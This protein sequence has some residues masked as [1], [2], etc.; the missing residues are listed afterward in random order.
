VTWD[1]WEYRE[2][3]SARVALA[4]GWKHHPKNPQLWV[5]GEREIFTGYYTR[6]RGRDA[7]Q[8]P[9]WDPAD[10][11]HLALAAAGRMAD[12]R[13]AP[14][15]LTRLRDGLWRAAFTLGGRYGDASATDQIPSR[16]ICAAILRLV[17]I[18]DPERLFKP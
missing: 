7:I 13:R 1:D 5:E 4:I 10:D 8:D 12:A 16:A 11:S 2:Q 3:I 6:G 14:F 18:P 17:E 15:T 9:I